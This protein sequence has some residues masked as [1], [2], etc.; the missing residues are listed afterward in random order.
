[1]HGGKKELEIMDC[2]KL[3]KF[4]DFLVRSFGVLLYEIFSMGVEPYPDVDNV[5]VY[6]ELQ[7]GLK[8]SWPKNCPGPL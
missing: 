3:F 2:I 8:L 1:M 5:K 4:M 7:N 6:L